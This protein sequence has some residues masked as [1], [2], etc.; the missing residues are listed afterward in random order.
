MLAAIAA[1]LVCQLAVTF[2]GIALGLNGLL[3]AILVPLLLP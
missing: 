3:T 1:L 2:V